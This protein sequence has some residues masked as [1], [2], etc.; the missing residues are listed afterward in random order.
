MN[1]IKGK[2]KW[3]RTGDSFHAIAIIP[4]S[5]HPEDIDEHF[6]FRCYH[7]HDCCGCVSSSIASTRPLSGDRLAVRTYGWRNI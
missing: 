6:R 7:E 4:A 1:I 5:T 2:T 3:D